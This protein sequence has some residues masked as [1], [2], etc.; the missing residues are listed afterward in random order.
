MLFCYVSTSLVGNVIPVYI[1]RLVWRLSL[2]SAIIHPREGARVFR[3]N[4]N[5]NNSNCLNIKLLKNL[6]KMGVMC[7]IFV[8]KPE[9]G[10]FRP[11]EE[12]TGIV[13][14]TFD[15]PTEA[16]DI[17]LSLVGKGSCSFDR[18]EPGLGRHLLRPTFYHETEDYICQ[19][20]QILDKSETALQQGTY[21]YPFQFV[22]PKDIP[23]SYHDRSEML[24]IVSHRC[25][26]SY[27]ITIKFEM[28]GLFANKTYNKEIIVSAGFEQPTPN[29]PR[30]YEG[31]KTLFAPFTSSNNIVR[32]KGETTKSFYSPSE[33]IKLMITIHNDTDI[34]L[35]S[36]RC[37]LVRKLLLRSKKIYNPSYTIEK[38]VEKVVEGCWITA[39]GIPHGE[40]KS[41]PVAVP[42][43]P[44][45]TIKNSKIISVEYTVKV[46]AVIPFPHT[47]L[48]VEV[49]IVIGEIIEGSR[50]SPANTTSDEPPPYWEAMGEDRPDDK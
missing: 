14:Y 17:V 3:C 30:C 21:E 16:K 11:G 44:V 26:I 28:P 29:E 12:V 22:L 10:I 8:R 7:Q 32:L 15:E 47:N 19:N 33:S 20:K 40:E 43:R 24:S 1:S 23:S 42:T 34:T 5:F 48:S 25:T 41:F 4:L 2:L 38:C 49:P 39:P 9:G 50:V 13:K 31:A 37:E 45:C 35:D 6:I 36:I 46:T 27:N 18:V